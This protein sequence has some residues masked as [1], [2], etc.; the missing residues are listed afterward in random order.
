[1]GTSLNRVGFSM[2]SPATYRIVVVGHL[3]RAQSDRLAG[4]TIEPIEDSGIEGPRMT[5]LFGTL[6]DQAQLIGVMNSL[7]E[8]RLS[9]IA[10]DSDRTRPSRVLR[11]VNSW[12]DTGLGLAN[13]WVNKM[14][15]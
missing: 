7:H 10:L 14:A 5:T 4:M 3:N 6:V 8:M 2:G 9:I 1:M 12:M 15:G 13:Y 11:T